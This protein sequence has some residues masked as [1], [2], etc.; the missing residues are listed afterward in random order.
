M[1]HTGVKLRESL[2]PDSRAF[3]VFDRL[4]REIG[5]YAINDD[6]PSPY[7]DAHD[8]GY[9]RKWIDLLTAVMNELDPS[10]A[11]TRASNQY[12][13]VAGEQYDAIRKVLRVMKLA[14]GR[15]DV[16]DPYLDESVFNFIDALDERIVLRL[17][18]G[19]RPKSSFTMLLDAL[20]T[21]RPPTEARATAQFHDRFL[22]LDEGEVWQIGTSLNGLGKATSMLTRVTENAQKD[23]LINQF[24]SAWLAGTPL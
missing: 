17:L 24:Q 14:R 11:A 5:G 2:D 10:A 12:V 8:C 6:A 20:K 9:A 3:R 16:I 19:S 18:T 21:K 23:Q 22:V 1:R 13:L 15:L 4:E 7:T